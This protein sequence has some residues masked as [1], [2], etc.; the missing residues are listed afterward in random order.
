KWSVFKGLDG[1]L[2]N[3]RF[4]ASSGLSNPNMPFHG[5][6][7]I[8]F[9]KLTRQPYLL[10]IQP[11]GIHKYIVGGSDRE[12]I[13]R[14]MGAT[15]DVEMLIT[16]ATNP[17]MSTGNQ[18]SVAIAFEKIPFII[19]FEIFNSETTE[20]FADIVLPDTCYLEEGAWAN[21]LAQN[22]NHAWG[23]DDW[24]YHIAQPVV[25]PKAQRRHSYEVGLEILDRLGEKWDRELIAEANAR[26][27]S[28]WPIKDEYQLKPEDRPT[29]AEVGDRVVK[30]MFGPEHDWE[31]FKKKGFIKW[32]KK[33]EE[34]YWMWFLDL[35]IPIYMEFLAHMGEEIEKINAETG[36]EFNSEQYTPLISW[37]PCK[38]H[39]VTDPEHDLCCYS[40]RDIL[41]SASST[42]EQPWLDEASLMNPY[43][44]N[45]TMNAATAKQ[46][47]I[48]D[49]DAVEV[50]T[51]QGRKVTGTLKT[52]EG[53]HPLTVGIAATAGHWAK[54]QP[55]ARGK[56]SNF[57]T[58][59]PMDWEHMDP[60]CGTIETAIRVGIR[61]VS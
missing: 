11:I 4:G 2:Q 33:V 51:Y 22:F 60:I 27:N 7:P 18:D 49:G 43:T 57:D 56:G 44:Y 34:A 38:N 59:L 47:G 26:F 9:P 30:S 25:E 61:K 20:G 17:V 48:K 53:H 31:W 1:F 50:E 35:R 42:M 14:K 41:H 3:E 21:G 23:M 52:M 58:L 15:Y 16:L 13:W 46:K 37:F 32:P 6:W 55:I 36:L 8:Q 45:I 5:E 28:I 29:I 40:Y 19:S 54:G 10:D 39:K 12:E 24:C